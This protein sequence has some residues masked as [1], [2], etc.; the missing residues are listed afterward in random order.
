MD[1]AELVAGG[2]F[3]LVLLIVVVPYLL[4]VV[5]PESA[6]RDML[7]QRIKTGGAAVRP[8]G[9][10]LLKEA[11]KLSVIG[12]LHKALSGEDRKSVV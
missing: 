1:T 12:P 10:S 2:T 7:R 8:A 6:T 4:L 5:R 9:Q 3:V 11:E